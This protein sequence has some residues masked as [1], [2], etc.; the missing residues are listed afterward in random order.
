MAWPV[1][2]WRLGSLV[3]LAMVVIGLGV[4][5]GL[6]LASFPEEPDVT[7][8]LA[9]GQPLLLDIYR[10]RGLKSTRPGVILIHGGGWVEGNKSSQREL[11]N[12]LTEA[13]YV[14]IAVGYRLARD[15]RSRYPA[16]AD[17]VRQAVRWVRSNA[18]YVGIDP[19]RLGVF[20]HSAGG[21]LA[22]LLGTTDLPPPAGT[23]LR[24]PSSRATC[25]VDCCGPTDFT[26]ETSP[27]V[28]P[29]IADVIPRFFGKTRREAP[30]AYRDASPVSHVDALSAPTLIIHGT[31]DQI[32]PIDQSRK[33]RDAL[34]QARVEVKL[35]E[36]EGEG[37]LFQA[38]GSK[39]KM[40]LE[41]LEFFR[42]HLKP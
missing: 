26:D 10:P 27:P 8:G 40:L 12:S 41:T 38:P 21:H 24:S 3:G 7:Y 32:V 30:E 14:A 4:F 31:S 29:S 2:G 13:G 20:G 5:A 34:Q 35:V 19:D 42:R 16:Q 37:H 36:L 17:D 23:S 22:A 39:N 25:V 28:G 33:L 15:D 9:D 11:A 18:A 6:R 1:R